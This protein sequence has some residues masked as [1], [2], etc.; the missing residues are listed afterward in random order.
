MD[1]EKAR[2]LLNECL[3]KHPIP[4]TDVVI[5]EET[6]FA[7]MSCNSY[8]FKGLMCLVYDLEIKKK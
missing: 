8:T 7:K 4:I 6:N 2:E 3:K 1:K 5:F